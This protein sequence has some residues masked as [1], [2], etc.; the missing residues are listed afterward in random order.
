[1]IQKVAVAIGSGLQLLCEIRQLR[2]MVSIQLRIVRQVLW[3]LLMMRETVE[4]AG[5]ATLGEPLVPGQGVSDAGEVTRSEKSRDAR[6]VGLEGQC[7]Q[8][9]MQFDMRVEV[10]R[11]A[12]WLIDG[13]H[14]GR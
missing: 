13:R 2:D 5:T 8:I 10:I 6:D 4:T 9:E 12:L 7:R 3:N 14:R 1:M 11:N